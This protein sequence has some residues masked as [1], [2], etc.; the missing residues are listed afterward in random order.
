MLSQVLNVG[1]MMG[2]K[3]EPPGHGDVRHGCREAAESVAV[4]R[5]AVDPDGGL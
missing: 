2:F 1:H 5:G 4:V 3:R